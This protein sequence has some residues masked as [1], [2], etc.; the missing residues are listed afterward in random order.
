MEVFEYKT[1]RQI[2]TEKRGN[3]EIPQGFQVFLENFYN[4]VEMG[5]ISYI[6]VAL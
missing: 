3:C 6:L 5:E 2:I 1:M 4:Y